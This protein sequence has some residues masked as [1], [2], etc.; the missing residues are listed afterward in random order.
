MESVTNGPVFV[1]TADMLQSINGRTKT[2]H[3][4]IAGGDYI[5]TCQKSPANGWSYYV[6]T[7][8]RQFMQKVYS[9]R[10]F[11]ITA[12]LLLALIGSVS[13]FLI[14]LRNYM[15]LRELAD[16]I[17]IGQ[18]TSAQ[19]ETTDEIKC[20]SQYISSLSKQNQ[21][22]EIRQAIRDILFDRSTNPPEAT[23]KRLLIDSGIFSGI[24]YYRVLLFFSDS[25]DACYQNHLNYSDIFERLA[26][27]SGIS[28]SF[29]FEHADNRSFPILLCY[30][31]DE[32][33][34]CVY[35]F[36]DSVNKILGSQMTFTVGIGSAYPSVLDGN[37]SMHQAS[38]AIYYRVI[39]GKNSI[40]DYSEIQTTRRHYVYPF[41]CEQNLTSA[42]KQAKSSD[43]KPIMLEIV[44]YIKSNASNPDDARRICIGLAYAV[45]H[46]LE[47]IQ[48]D[49]N[50]FDSDENY[51][52]PEPYEPV[53]QFASRVSN[54]CERVCD[55]LNQ[56]K[57]SRYEELAQ[58]AKRYIKDNF[59]DYTLSLNSIADHCNISASYLSRFFKTQYE[60]SV[61]QFIDRLR[62]ECAKRL[63][64]ETN[65]N[66]REITTKSGYGSETNFIRKFK[67]KEGVTPMQYR[68]VMC[69]ARSS[70][71]CIKK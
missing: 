14:A 29:C 23:A 38:A 10:I 13:V 20:I 69:N 12:L 46:T 34:P 52:Y 3:I 30:T 49:I 24:R 27:R 62:M 31:D 44:S 60:E 1:S 16:S 67:K 35:D 47:E 21:N 40:I 37:K 18:H 53:E 41:E 43:I 17:N 55:Y 61:A 2:S 36:I 65:L 39:R 56:H 54:L 22:Y 4:S 51:L 26:A 15:P 33:S 64:S 50:T 25:A 58:R 59:A 48:I 32:S 70:L 8:S 66:L 57:E 5:L 71:L 42:I 6:V 9:S 11:F 45:V 7:D 19:E 63:L 68:E 28:Q